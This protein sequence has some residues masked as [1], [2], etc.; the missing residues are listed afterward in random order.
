MTR[1]EQQRAMILNQVQRSRVL[2]REAAQVLGLSI[3][4]LKRLL[5]AYR[6]RG[7]VALIHGNRG[8]QPA[9]A[10]P[11]P[12]KARVRDLA[13]AY[14]R[15]N[16]THFT[17]LLA[18]REGV[19]LS[20][21]SVRRILVAAGHRSP[22]TRRAPQH[23]RRRDRLPLPGLLVQLDG[24][25]HA[26]LEDRGPRPVL[27]GAIDDATS[28]VCFAQFRADEDAHGY[29]VLLTTLGRTHG[30]PVAVYSDRHSIFVHTPKRA[31][32]L[33]EELTGIP[34]PTQ[35][36]RALQQLGI[37]WIGAHS[38]QAKGRIERLWGTFQDRLVA[39]LRLAGASTLDEAN[40]VLAAFLP[41]FNRRF[42]KAAPQP[43]SAWRPV[44]KDLDLDAI[45][46]FHYP[47]TVR[48][49][50]AVR[51]GPH[52]LDIPP[53][54]GGRTYARAR[55][56]IQERLD[57][58]LTV[59]YQGRCLAQQAAPAQT[60]Q[61]LRARKRQPLVPAK[62]PRVTTQRRR[63]QPRAARRAPASGPWRPAP[64]HP[65]RRTDTRAKARKAL[66]EAGVTFS[67]NT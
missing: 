64:D 24:S 51:L 57:G 1:K 40:A 17:E 65:W 30:L 48:N 8:R 16:H 36:G 26:W 61:A 20:R 15:V 56:T 23:R 7:P 60:P 46:C 37:Q 58:S 25:H 50:N 55:V 35:V 42:A 12:L 39:E 63:P 45:C 47:A 18:E 4:H 21:P 6:A 52:L 3:R 13:P 9:H 49:D 14:S 38:P 2:I 41:R 31:L 19:T 59:Y 29:F 43:G 53:G 54:P 28:E 11:E 10:L 22:R 33:D 66:R 32:S 34:A 27:L 44:P 62:P 5:A 67:R